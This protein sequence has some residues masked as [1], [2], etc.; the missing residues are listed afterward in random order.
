MIENFSKHKKFFELAKQLSEK[1]TYCHKLGAVVTKKGRILGV[2]FNTN[3]THTRA[4]TPYKTVHAEFDAIQGV[5]RNDL[6]NSIMY[7]FREHRSGAPALSKPCKCCELMLRTFGIKTVYY[8][9]NGGYN[10]YDL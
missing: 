5:S 6:I 4:N 7:V 2:G 8:T 9:S 10:K 1:S 3:K